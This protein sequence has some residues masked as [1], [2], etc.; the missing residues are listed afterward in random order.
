M[1]LAGDSAGPL[2]FDRTNGLLFWKTLLFF[3]GMPSSFREEMLISLN[4]FTG[5]IDPMEGSGLV[6][7]AGFEYTL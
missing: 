5:E 6:Y 7:D 1:P 2:L 3:F 4:C